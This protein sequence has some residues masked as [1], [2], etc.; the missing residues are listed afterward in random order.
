LIAH[1]DKIADRFVDVFEHHLAPEDW[2]HD[3]D[4]DRAR[5]LA[6]TLARLQ[7]TARQVVVAALDASVAKVGRERLALLI[8]GPA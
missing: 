8:D 2:R 3:L 7:A 5:E 6:A 1:T 4:T